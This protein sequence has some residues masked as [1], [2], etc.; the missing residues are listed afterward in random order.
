MNYKN[1]LWEKMPTDIFKLFSTVSDL[2]YSKNTPSG[3]LRNCD[4]CI[5]KRHGPFDKCWGDPNKLPKIIFVQCKSIKFFY[6]EIYKNIPK[7]HKYVLIMGDEDIT[8][9]INIDK[10]WSDGYWS[11]KDKWDEF[12]NNENI[13]QIYCT[14]LS[15]PLTE[16]VKP[17][18]VGLNPYEING[19]NLDNLLNTKKNYDFSKKKDKIIYTSRVRD[20]LQWSDRK[21]VSELILHSSWKNFSEKTHFPKD[22]FHTNI[23]EYSFMACPHGGGLE[24]NP[25]VFSCILFGVFPIVK[26]FVNC[27]YLYKDLPIFYVNDWKESE[28][29]IKKLL[30]FKKNNRHFFE[31]ELERDKMQTKLYSKYYYDKIMSIFK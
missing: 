8:L 9:P 19:G 15:I 4:W 16:K 14:H 29:T 20:G 5:G 30:D 23:S 13:L 25:N 11:G 26:K 6:N 21:I 10:R 24:P 28:I 7:N 22:Q 31:N 17:L 12:I 2:I 1:L 18:P 27:E 3:F